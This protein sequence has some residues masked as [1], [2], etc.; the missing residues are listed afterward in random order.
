MGMSFV[1]RLSLKARV[2]WGLLLGYTSF[3][4]YLHFRTQAIINSRKQEYNKVIREQATD[5]IDVSK[6]KSS[7]VAGMF[8]NPFEEYR[9]QTVF[10]FLLVRILE[11]LES[12]YGSKIEIHQ[13]LPHPHDGAVEVEDILK[14]FQPDLE[15]FRKNS[16]ILSQC[17]SK[18]DY[19]D[20]SVR[21]IDPQHIQRSWFHT[22]S[23]VPPG[24]PIHDQL[25][26]T[27][28]GQSCTLV[29]LAGVNFLTDPIISDHLFSP[30][31]GPKRLTKSP[32]TIDSIK[33]ATNDKLDFVIVSHDHPDHLEYD[34]AK[35]IGNNSMWIV[36]LGL[37]RKLGRKG[38]YK[39]IEMDWWEK[40]DITRYISTDEN[41]PDKY[42]IECLPSMHWSGRYAFDSNWSLWCS[43]AIRR[44]GECILY[45]TGD[46]GYSKELF[47]VIGKRLGSVTLGL[48]P[49]GQYCPSWHQKPRHISPEECLKICSQLNIKYMKGIHWGTYKLSSEPI[50]EPMTKLEKLAHKQGKA[51][52]YRVPEFGLTYLFDLNNKTETEIHV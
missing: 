11:L 27:W 2:G 23:V 16:I 20:L 46:T 31:F 49:I 39:V 18:N 28:L 35:H 25:L 38:I 19:S 1:S 12:V 42:E 10:E 17:L 9:N 21:P 32:M 40:L 41:F 5:D 13:K 43:Y 22:K 24:P 29:Q 33:Y 51:I 34:F 48:L 52:Q 45:H 15:R 8:I 36:P 3:E 6:F 4:V 26:F 50:L 47:D 44:N 7:L 37:K 14:V 30:K